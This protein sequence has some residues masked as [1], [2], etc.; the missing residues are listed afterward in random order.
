MKVDHPI[1]RVPA[2]PEY[3]LACFREERHQCAMPN[4]ESDDG[5]S[6]QLPTFETTI[7][8]WREA[9]DLVWW[10]PLGQGLNK[11]WGLGNVATFRG[12]TEAI[13]AQQRRHGFGPEKS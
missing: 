13:V 6:Q 9:L 4:G 1:E 10:S 8:E 5:K 7:H 3:V 11:L 12:L 2:T